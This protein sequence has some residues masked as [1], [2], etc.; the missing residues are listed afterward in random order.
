M[1]VH[2]PVNLPQVVREQN[3]IGKRWYRTPQGNKYPSITTVLGHQEKPWLKEWRA[4]LGEKKAD[5]ETQRCAVRGTNIH[6]LIERYLKNEPYPDFTSG[7]KTQ[8]VSGFNQIKHRLNNISNIRAQEAALYSDVLKVAGTVDCIG[9]FENKLSV[10]DFKT[11]NN[12]K[13]R[14]AI[15]DYFL[16]TTAY[17][18]MWEEMTGEYIEDIVILMTVEKGMTSLVF[19]EKIDKYVAPLIKRIREYEQQ[20]M[21]K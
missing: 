4:S 11:S 16:Q 19:K 7:Y 9:Q 8:Y 17:A 10:I 13:Y 1:F 20:G 14:E 15:E 12:N 6:E 3:L 21:S 5:K 2:T 18:I